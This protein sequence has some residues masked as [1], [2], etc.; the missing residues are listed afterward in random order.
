MKLTHFVPLATTILATTATAGTVP[1]DYGFNWAIIGDPGNRATLDS[2]IY[3]PYN[4]YPNQ[5]LGAVNYEYRMATTEV[6]VGQYFEFAQVYHPYY[7][8]NTGNDLGLSDFTGGD[9]RLAWGEI[10]IR[11]GTSPD[12]PIDMGWEYAARYVNWLHNGKVN[13]EWA[14]ETGVY[15]TSTFTQNPDG[16]WNHQ[17]QH[18]PDALFWLPSRDEWTKAAYWD[19]ELNNG[20]G[21]YW[22][23]TTS[24]DIEPLP[25][26]ERNTGFGPDFPLDVGSFP[27][28]MSPWGILDLEGGVS[29]WTETVSSHD[30]RFIMGPSSF[31]GTYGDP[32]YV[33]RLGRSLTSHFSGSGG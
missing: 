6:T 29:E 30:D 7:T 24:S 13:E 21:G 32:F 5:H 25:G 15:D 1:P 11:G 4:L 19:P 20:E 17:A 28:I 3:D 33:G 14:F 2:E 31:E 9:I 22:Q 10:S 12:K 8:A 18:N 16:S 23:F 26:I 27:D